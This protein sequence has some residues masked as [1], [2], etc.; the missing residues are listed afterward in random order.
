MK[1]YRE[2][3]LKKMLD[4]FDRRSASQPNVV[5]SERQEQSAG[6]QERACRRIFLKPTEVYRAYDDYNADYHRKSEIGEAA[7]FLS[8]HGFIEVEYLPYSKDIR[9]MILVESSVVSAADWLETEYG[10]LSRSTLVRRMEELCRRYDA[11]GLVKTYTVWLREEVSR[12]GVTP[13]LQ[14]M[15][16]VL[17]MLSFLEKND[18]TLYVREASMLVYGDSKYFEEKTMTEVCRVL[19]GT[20]TGLARYH[21]FPGEQEI[22]IKGAWKISF[23]GE[24]LNVAAISGGVSLSSRCFP[25]IRAIECGSEVMTVENKTSYERMPED[26]RAYLYLGGFATDEQVSFIKMTASGNPSAHFSHF[27]DIDAGGFFIHRNLCERTGISFQIY[28]MGIGELEDQAFANC[29][30][31]LTE[32]DRDRLTGLVDD[33]RYREVVRYMLEKNVKLEQEIVSY[34]EI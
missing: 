33:E 20:D 15:E 2:I 25:G 21:V 22:R 17:R 26:G 32:N 34:Y 31:P 29:L 3:I 18:R 14:H 9:R 23:S 7:E 8:G 11:P 12:P 24:T 1:E 27:G 13:D 5:E 28:R 19:D 6:G 4:K 30:H 10:I 16:D